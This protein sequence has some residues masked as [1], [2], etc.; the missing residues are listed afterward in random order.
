MH[1]ALTCRMKAYIQPFEKRLALNE[2]TQ[3][4]NAPPRSVDESKQIYAVQVADSL[5]LRKLITRLA[6]W[7]TVE[8]IDN[9]MFTVQVLRERTVNLVR[10]GVAV[11]EIPSLV[12][13]EKEISLPNRRCLRYGTHGI[14]EY[15]GKFFPQL[16]RA[17]L[18]I[19]AVPERGI[20]ADPMC[21]SGTTLVEAVLGN[22]HALGLDMNPLSV[23]LSKTKCALLSMPPARLAA[24]YDEMRRILMRPNQRRRIRAL[25]YF[26]QLSPVDQIYLRSWFSEQVINDLDQIAG[27]IFEI[28][29]GTVRDFM[30][31]GLSNILRSVSWQKDDDLRVRKEVRLDVEIDP[32]RE[33]LE[34]IG[35][36]VRLVL[37]FLYRSREDKLGRFHIAKGDAREVKGTWKRWVG[38]VD[39][40]VTSPPY[41]TALPYLDTDRLSLC[42]LQLL[43]RPQHRRHDQLM[44]G[45]REISEKTRSDYLALYRSRRADLPGSIVRLIDKV[46]DLNSRND[47]GFRRRNLAAL[48]AKYFMDMEQV[49]RGMNV[50]LKPH[51]PAYVVIGNN[52]TIAGGQKVEI[53]TANLLTDLASSVGLLPEDN[54]PMEM[55][56]SRDIF[57][58]NTVSSEEILCLRKTR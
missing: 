20:V 49:M 35:R 33:F 26:K 32:V 37:A 38:K 1:R 44:I 36:S 28:S 7:E 15:R 47:V 25:T 8:E 48:L 40:I 21:G 55:L 30:R 12:Q 5:D 29:D 52:H 6:Y 11:R 57:R 34:E 51:S 41:A 3:I 39:A 16:V 43:S 18:N 54:K 22:C 53:N 4:S 56:V 23:L 50:A 42:Y 9:E 45:N 24:A 17:L 19:G 10:N 14:H 2:L 46:H 58:R 27:A 13:N 31:L